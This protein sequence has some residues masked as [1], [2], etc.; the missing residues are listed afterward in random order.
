VANHEQVLRILV[1]R[2]A[3]T[4]PSQLWLQPASAAPPSSLG[5]VPRAPT[6][7]MPRRLEWMSMV[8]V[9][10]LLIII[11]PVPTHVPGFYAF[12]KRGRTSVLTV[13]VGIEDSHWLNSF[14]FPQLD[15]L[16][17]CQ[18]SH[19]FLRRTNGNRYQ[20]CVLLF[21]RLFGTG[22]TQ[23]RIF[24]FTRSGLLFTAFRA[25]FHWTDYKLGGPSRL[26][27]KY[28]AWTT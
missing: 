10:L 15:R 8:I 9:I 28:S 5:G 20:S 27:D 18:L 22:T 3:I 13:C 4:Y 6:C 11:I 1:Y 7:V 14:P 25:E 12:W 21:S 23:W 2:A 26:Q 24:S 19:T 16:W 17:S